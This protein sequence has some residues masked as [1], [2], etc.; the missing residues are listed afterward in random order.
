MS[1]SDVAEQPLTLMSH[2]GR[3]LQAMSGCFTSPHFN[4]RVNAL[5]MIGS[6]GEAMTAQMSVDYNLLSVAPKSASMGPI[7]TTSTKM[8]DVFPF[9]I[10][11]W[12]WLM[13]LGRPAW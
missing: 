12:W 4:A 2:R 11:C 6:T 7:M 10:R 1:L 8:E 3:G 9:D 5:W 13:G